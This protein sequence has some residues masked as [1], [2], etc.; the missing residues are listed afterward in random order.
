MKSANA[1]PRVLPFTPAVSEPIQSSTEAA[2][3]YGPRVLRALVVLLGAVS[4]HVWGIP[5]PHPQQMPLAAF[6][7]RIMRPPGAPLAPPLQVPGAVDVSAGVGRAPHG[8]EQVGSRT[9]WDTVETNTG[10]GSVHLS[11]D[12]PCPL[13]GHA[14]HSYLACS[15]TCAC[16][17]TTMPG[18]VAVAV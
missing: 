6:V 4:L 1:S 13:C 3:P 18:T 2:A 15:D 9:M 10:Q 8:L 14:A 12:L 16:V 11:H 5:A 7:S 17:P